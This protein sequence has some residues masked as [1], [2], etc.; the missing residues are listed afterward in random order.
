MQSLLFVVRK[1]EAF[2]LVITRGSVFEIVLFVVG[3]AIS[4]FVRA[5][6]ILVFGTDFDLWIIIAGVVLR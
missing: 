5:V 6:T 2:V 3:C 1:S 4:I